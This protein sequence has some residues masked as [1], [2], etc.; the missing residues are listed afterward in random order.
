MSSS[1]KKKQ[2]IKDNETPFFVFTVHARRFVVV[3]LRTRTEKHDGA[4]ANYNYAFC[5]KTGGS[6]GKAIFRININITVKK[7][8][9]SHLI[10]NI[11]FFSVNFEHK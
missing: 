8:N 3:I 2:K 10:S 1:N 9:K 7:I 5:L 6:T 4:V 11:R